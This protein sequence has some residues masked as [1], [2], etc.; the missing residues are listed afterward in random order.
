MSQLIF[1]VPQSHCVAIERFGKFNRLC[2]QGLHF[3]I[4]IM[5]TMHVVNWD[6]IA[7]KYGY[8]IEL[9][10]QQSDTSARQCHTKDNVALSVDATI[11]WRIVDPT[12]ALYAVDVL[13]KQL[14]DSALNALRSN[15]GALEL[16]AVLTGRQNLNQRITANLAK[17]AQ[18]WGVRVLRVE[19]QQL[20]TS[21]ETATAMRQEMEA[22]RGRRAAI[23]I[24]EGE[25]Q[26]QVRIAEAER[27][28]MILRAD[29]Q[30]KVLRTIA[31]AELN[32]LRQLGEA[33]SPG[34][35]AQVLIAQ[36]VLEGFDKISD[37]AS[38][39]V[40]LP[41]SFNGLFSLPVDRA[42]TDQSP[43]PGS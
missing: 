27:K 25:A 26:A 16:D 10:E 30:A 32:Y 42:Q 24:A 1:T 36:K 22:E 39:K 14:E 38:H 43:P 35:A 15:I 28:S 11:Y 21:D 6:G 18:K 33:I 23:A 41:N 7:N 4:P 2:P 9:A 13:P 37:N 3:K 34:Q 20:D 8:L 40:F 17:I 19:I 29:G 5:E 12:R 31:D